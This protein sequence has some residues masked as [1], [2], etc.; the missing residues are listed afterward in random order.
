ME[1]HDHSDH[2]PVDRNKLRAVLRRDVSVSNGVH[3][4]WLPDCEN[5]GL[6]GDDLE[7]G[8]LVRPALSGT[9]RFRQHSDKWGFVRIDDLLHLCR[10]VFDECDEPSSSHCRNVEWFEM[11]DPQHTRNT[12]NI[13]RRCFLRR[14]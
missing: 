10:R 5:N 7:W 14:K 4:G 13:S 8:H 3:R 6:D 2:Q 1:G 12:W 11:D 9:A